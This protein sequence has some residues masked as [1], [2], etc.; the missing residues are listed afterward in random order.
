MRDVTLPLTAR[1]LATAGLFA[2][3]LAWDEFFCALRFTSDQRARH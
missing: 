2:F 3:L 1:G